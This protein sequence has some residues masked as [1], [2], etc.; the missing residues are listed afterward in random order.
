[1]LFSKIVRALHATIGRR[2]DAISICCSIGRPISVSLVGT[3]GIEASSGSF[4]ATLPY[5]WFELKFENGVP[6]GKWLS[7]RYSTSLY[8]RLVRPVLRFEGSMPAVELPISAALFGRAHWIGWVPEQTTKVLISPTNARGPFGFDLERCK[9]VSPTSIIGLALIRRPIAVLASIAQ[10][11]FGAA[12]DARN[13]LRY[14]MAYR[15]TSYHS[16]RTAGTRDVDIENLERPRGNRDA[17]E[18]H[19]RVVLIAHGA[20][21]AT[22]VATT[23]GSLHRQNYASWSKCILSPAGRP[24]LNDQR[25]ASIGPAKWIP[26]VACISNVWSDCPSHSIFVP[27]VFGDVI[28]N[29]AL[30]ALAEHVAIYPEDEI[31]YGDEDEIDESGRFLNPKLKPDWSP[32]FESASGYMGSAIFFRST[33][34]A[35]VGDLCADSFSAPDRLA[36]HFLPSERSQVGHLRRVMLTKRM[37]RR[38]P[39]SATAAHAV[40]V[41]PKLDRSPRV[42]IIIPT[43]D[44]AEL[45]KNCL[46]S[47][48]MTTYTNFEIIVADNGSIDPATH[49]LF[50]ARKGDSRLR[51]IPM[52]GTFNFS[53]LCNRAAAHANS[54]ILAFLNN[55]TVVLQGDWLEQIVAWASQTEVG[56]V[57][58][59]LVFPS[60]RLQHIGVA[61]GIGGYAA[62]IDRGLLPGQQSYLGRAVFP[63]EVSAVTGACLV[64]EKSKFNLVGG[65]DEVDFPIELGDID[66]CLRLA[67]RG[68]KTVFLP[69]PILVHLESASR[70]SRGSYNHEKTN[71]RKK[72]RETIRDDQYFHPALSLES[73]LTML[74]P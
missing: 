14:A 64:V 3:V 21:A 55:D 66:L 53:F 45:L 36:T 60:G 1:M 11:L 65:F 50:D 7:L 58:V 49:A 19:I 42:T 8:D 44:R 30:A 34:L 40:F 74:G 4:V 9:I 13:S 63:H 12:E 61:I 15:L 17:P 24:A 25:F 5:P 22:D 18:L 35:R 41:A 54:S 39:K 29:Y 28:P 32:I 72:W 16:W 57:G 48:D 6:A 51:I 33:Y 56:A 47:I 71:F 52:P 20:V 38:K 37:D 62:H 2:V 31:I 67:R 68:L 70:G 73:E 59:K 46:N 69:N 43:R 27:I 26:S 23:I 10:F